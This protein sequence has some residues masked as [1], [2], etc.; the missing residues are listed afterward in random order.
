MI[1]A[2]LRIQSGSLA[3]TSVEPIEQLVGKLELGRVPLLG[4]VETSCLSMQVAM[5]AGDVE[6]EPLHRTALIPRPRPVDTERA[7]SAWSPFTSAMASMIDS[8]ARL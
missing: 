1:H 3:L 5:P 2:R 8:C 7:S 6:D 4:S